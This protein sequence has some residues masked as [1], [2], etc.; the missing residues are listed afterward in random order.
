MGKLKLVLSDWAFWLRGFFPQRLPIGAKAFDDFCT[1]LLRAYNLPDH[2]SYR[3]AIAKTILHFGP[4]TWR[5]APYFFVI[6][7]R[8]GQARQV[9]WQFSEDA[10][11]E[12]KRQALELA[13]KEK[14]AAEAPQPPAQGEATPNEAAP[15]APE[16]KAA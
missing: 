13:A 10:R 3:A 14:A 16:E 12:E 8:A 5:K 9:A 1:Q 6:C 11:A 4:Q 2:S 15:L 7:I